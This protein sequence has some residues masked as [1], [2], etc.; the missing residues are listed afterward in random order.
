MKA[1]QSFLALQILKEM[2]LWK[3]YKEENILILHTDL[4]YTRFTHTGE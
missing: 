1:W 2:V 4:A 3:M